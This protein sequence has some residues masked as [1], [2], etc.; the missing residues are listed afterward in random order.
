MRAAA[1]ALVMGASSLGGPSLA[2]SPMVPGVW[3]SFEAHLVSSSASNGTADDASTFARD[4]CRD[5]EALGAGEAYAAAVGAAVDG[6]A[7]PAFACASGATNATAV[8]TATGTVADLRNATAAEAP[9]LAADLAA[10]ATLVSWTVSALA[11]PAAPTAAPTPGGEDDGKAEDDRKGPATAFTW[12]SRSFF[13]YVGL[14]LLFLAFVLFVLVIFL[15]LRR[16]IRKRWRACVKRWGPFSCCPNAGL[17][18]HEIRMRQ[19]SEYYGK[20]GNDPGLAPTKATK[21]RPPHT[22]G[23]RS[24]HYAPASPSGG[25]SDPPGES[26]SDIATFV[27][28]L[29][30]A[31]ITPQTHVI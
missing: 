10:T 23:D 24:S 14:V 25:A 3:V 26:P 1:I 20:G 6:S 21:A 2:P 13:V 30:K 4:F 19:M 31:K 27:Q 15:G 29:R 28:S 22:S 8:L 7:G 11:A 5:F 16:P 12:S 9:P 18:R 17:S